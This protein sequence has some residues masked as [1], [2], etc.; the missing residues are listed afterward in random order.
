M[1]QALVV[2]RA[3]SLEKGQLEASQ[4][5]LTAETEA[6]RRRNEAERAVA[7]QAV[8]TAVTALADAL[9]RLSEGDLTFRLDRPFAPDY[10]PLRLDFN[11][12]VDKLET[13]LSEITGAIGGLKSGAGEIT[14]AADDLSR[15]T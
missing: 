12:A 2:F 4:S 5:A 13:T 11:S 14:Q 15:R 6:E 7:R 9:H 8:E 1:A 3:A 10:E